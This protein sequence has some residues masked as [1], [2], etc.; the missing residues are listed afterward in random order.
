MKNSARYEQMLK[1]YKRLAKK[2]DAQ[3]RTIERFSKLAQSDVYVTKWVTKTIKNKNGK[4]QKVRR[5]VTELTNKY[6]KYAHIKDMAYKGAMTDIKN[7]Y[8]SG[9]RFDRSAKGLS[10]AQLQK[11][12]DA[13]NDFLSK[14]TAYMKKDKKHGSYSD[15]LKR[16]AEGFSEEITNRLRDS[17]IISEDESISLTPEEIKDL[18]D[19]AEEQGLLDDNDLYKIME[20]ISSIKRDDKLKEAIDKVK[21]TGD[22]QGDATKI[23]KKLIKIGVEKSKSATLSTMITNG[24][25]FSQFKI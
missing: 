22:R 12:I 21:L 14:P 18:H 7:L 8:G 17:K 6:E 9:K 2:A 10:Q 25:D 24:V 16:A 4:K 23:R 11:R 3:L 13:I 20:I 19:I 15:A 5:K 1:E